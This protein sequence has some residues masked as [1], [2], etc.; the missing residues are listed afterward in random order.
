MKTRAAMHLVHKAYAPSAQGWVKPNAP[1]AQGPRNLMHVVH[2]FGP[3]SGQTL[4]TRCTPFKIYQGTRAFLG[5]A[6]AA[7]LA[8][9]GRSAPRRPIENHIGP[10][11]NGAKTTAAGG[12][13]S[14]WAIACWALLRYLGL[15]CRVVAEIGL[16][17]PGAFCAAWRNTQ[18]LG[19][20]AR[21]T[22]GSVNPHATDTHILG[23]A[24]L[25][26]IRESSRGIP[27]L[28]RFRYRSAG[29]RPIAGFPAIS[30]ARARDQ[31]RARSPFEAP[32][33]PSADSMLG[34]CGPHA[35]STAL[36]WWVTVDCSSPARHAHRCSSRTAE[37]F[38]NP[39][40]TVAYRVAAE[41]SINAPARPV[42]R[43]APMAV[44]GTA[45]R[46]RREHGK[47]STKPSAKG[48]RKG[49]AIRHGSGDDQLIE[50]GHARRWLALPAPPATPPIRG[51]LRR[52][53]TTTGTT[54]PGLPAFFEFSGDFHHHPLDLASLLGWRVAV[55][56]VRYPFC[57]PP[58][59]SANR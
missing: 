56:A 15:A 57:R 43:H 30:L 19:S 52:A 8:L 59:V 3:F 13:E 47:A 49:C 58:A 27:E 50:S 34:A 5:P 33:K 46:Q 12:H 55:L 21:I 42:Y 53:S 38:R 16:R 31:A 44:T 6:Q 18:T 37:P 24:R 25:A 22:T 2:L 11:T 40:E 39:F 29:V 14:E 4:C 51:S 1:G 7:A 26:T 48:S 20:S 17:A 45:Q 9:L 35:A 23:I 54:T 36:A 28:F 10:T 32:S 41:L